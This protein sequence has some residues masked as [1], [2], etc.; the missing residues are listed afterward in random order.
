LFLAPPPLPHDY[1]QWPRLEEVV[2]WLVRLSPRHRLWVVND[3]FIFAPPE[4]ESA[5]VNYA[6]SEGVELEQLAQIARSNYRDLPRPRSD[7]R[8][9]F[10]SSFLTGDRSERI[11]A[12]HLARLGIRQVLDIGANAGQF[13]NKLRRL[14]FGGIIY[15]VEPQRAAYEELLAST[16]SDT[17]WFPLPRQG[18]GAADQTME[19]NISENGWSSSL[20][21][22]HP[23]HVRAERSTRAV[24]V[25][26]VTIRAAGELLRPESM[27]GIE[28]LKI[29]VQGFEDRVL[30]GY[31]PWLPHI[32][33]LL[34]ELSMVE[35]Y[36]GAPDMFALDR[37]L[38]SE[39]G[40]SRVSLEPSYYDDSS[41]VVQ[42]YDGI[43]Y[44]P[45]P[46]PQPGL[47]DTALRVG[48]VVTS[49]GG[50]PQRLRFDGANVGR[51]WTQGCVQS[52]LEFGAPVSS[53]SETPAPSGIG[54]VQT[55]ARPTIGEMVE[56]IPVDASEHLLITNADIVF[57]PQ[58][59]EF[60]P[61]LDRRAVYYGQRV[62]VTIE[63]ASPD[64]LSVKGVYEYG[65]DYFLIPSELRRLLIE[66]RVLPIEFRIGEPW[67][68]YVVPL[69]G[70]ARGFPVKR[71][72][73]GAGALHFEH[74]ARYSDELW[75]RNGLIFEA[76]ITQFRSDPGNYA[77]GF[78]DALAACSGEPRDRLHKISQI[79]CSTL[80]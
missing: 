75:L 49:V 1:R 51:E 2:A 28:A 10:N 59:K 42:Q 69:F 64:R 44:R 39:F 5:I 22:V 54:W 63:P 74:P 12:H 40:F 70:L 77:R 80:P 43:Y 3:V 66:E 29:D 71:M 26:T 57:S 41:G 36:Q 30:D 4:A 8:A 50:E 68:D 73:S 20:L 7:G 6:R 55:A 24:G 79:V 23:N 13:A 32:R 37:R 9:N 35:C 48:A 72:P 17:R 11:F 67:W 53:V 19:L 62:D 15:S 46:N 78:F 14:G 45:S 65:F 58:F 34:L 25:E 31:R 61:M 56:A 52:W 47:D 76:L 16:R 60:L 38:V 33:L 27:A 18:A 21:A